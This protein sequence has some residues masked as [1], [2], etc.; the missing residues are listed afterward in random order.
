MMNNHAQ[1]QTKQRCTSTSKTT[2]HKH[3]Q[4]N[5][6]Q[7]QTKQR[8][9]STSKTKMHKHQQNNDAQALT[10]QNAPALEWRATLCWPSRCARPG[11]LKVATNY[12]VIGYTRR[13]K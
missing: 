4:N 5:D 8:Y 10:K 13:A 3:Q 2:M 1:T 7:A 12:R 9:T 11:T 6:A